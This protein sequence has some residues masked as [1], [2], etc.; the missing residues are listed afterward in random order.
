MTPQARSHTDSDGAER[1]G[2]VPQLAFW[3]CFF[4]CKALNFDGSCRKIQLVFCDMVGYSFLQ[5][6][7]ELHREYSQ[8]IQF[9][10][11]FVHTSYDTT[12]RFQN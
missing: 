11:V 9:Y 2:E 7:K 4:V 5:P 6:L 10:G 1:E 8:I 3:P 12:M